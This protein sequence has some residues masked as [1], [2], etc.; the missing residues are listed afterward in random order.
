MTG[1]IGEFLVKIADVHNPGQNEMASESLKRLLVPEVKGNET[2]NELRNQFNQLDIR[3]NEVIGKVLEDIVNKN[4]GDTLEF[5]ETP[6]YFVP[7]DVNKDA[8]AEG[9]VY[10]SSINLTTRKVCFCFEHDSVEYELK[11]IPLRRKLDM[12]ELL[13]TEQYLVETY[14]KK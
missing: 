9:F 11:D 3:L 14:R 6:E 8:D 12:L 5:T 4:L 2:Y 1:I 7:E 10:L 13:I